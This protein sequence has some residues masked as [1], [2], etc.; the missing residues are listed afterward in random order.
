MFLSEPAR[1]D[2][3][4]SISTIEV[5]HQIADGLMLKCGRRTLWKTP[6]GVLAKWQRSILKFVLLERTLDP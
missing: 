1:L 3:S 6:D 5:K 2:C 4:D